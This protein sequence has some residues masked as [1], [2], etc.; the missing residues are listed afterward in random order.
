MKY[1]DSLLDP[2]VAAPAAAPVSATESP[3][4]CVYHKMTAVSG[5]DV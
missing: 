1:R 3:Q 5:V 4:D 2:P